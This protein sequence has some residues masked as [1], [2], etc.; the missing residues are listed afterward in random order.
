MLSR[1]QSWPSLTHAWT[2]RVRRRLTLFMAVAVLLAGIAQAAHF[3]RDELT[4]GGTPDVHCVLCLFAAGSAAPP[5][6]AQLLNRETP[7]YD[8]PRPPAFLPAPQNPD[9]ASYDARGPPGV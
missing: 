7:R 3:H 9:G 5:A 8:I 6:I 2:A 4:G 1:R